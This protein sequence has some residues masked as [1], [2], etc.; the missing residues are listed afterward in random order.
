MERAREAPE[1]FN[2]TWP[3]SEPQG[4]SKCGLL[5]QGAVLKRVRIDAELKREVARATESARARRRKGGGGRRT[6]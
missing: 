4:L 5:D 3:C 6:V 2:M 1:S